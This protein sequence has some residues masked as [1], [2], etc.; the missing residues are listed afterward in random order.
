MGTGNQGLPPTLP[1]HAQLYIRP[2]LPQPAF[3]RESN[4]R[5]RTDDR[6]GQRAE[7]V[8]FAV[9]IRAGDQLEQAVASAGEIR[10]W[11][12]GFGKSQQQ[13]IFGLLGGYVAPRADVLGYPGKRRPLIMGILN[14]T[15][16]SFYDGGRHDSIEKAVAHGLALAESGADIVDVGG[17]STRPGAQ[18]V[19]PDEE[20]TRVVPVIE[21]LA[22]GG[23]TVSVDTRH[24]A[25]MGAALTSGAAMI[26]DV[27]ALTSD[28]ESLACVAETHVPVVL[29]HGFGAKG[30]DVPEYKHVVLDVY[31]FLEARVKAC[32]GA[33]IDR[34]RLILD[35]GLGFGKTADHSLALLRELTVLHGL[36]CPLLLGASRKRFIAHLCRGEPPSKRL[37]GSLAAALRGLDLGVRVLRVH[38]VAETVQARDLWTAMTLPPAYGKPEPTLPRSG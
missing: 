1:A 20:C 11:A 2:Q 22:A 37:A 6:S 29:G 19:F 10:R 12:G 34:S 23:V 25:T 5:G 26:N 28:C 17:E 7:S 18:P 4:E 35:P 9:L 32:V 14:V 36:G 16:D 13:R 15:P 3:E 38:D 21:A 30:H 31:D 8:T 27:S 24:A 33:G